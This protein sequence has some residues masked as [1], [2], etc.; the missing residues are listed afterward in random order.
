MSSLRTAVLPTIQRSIDF[1]RMSSPVSGLAQ[2]I[3]MD[4][5]GDLKIDL[6]GIPSPQPSSS[7]FKVW[8]NVWNSSDP[9]SS[10]FNMYVACSRRMC[11]PVSIQ[12]LFAVRT[13][14]LMAHSAH[15]PILIATPPWT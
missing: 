15:L 5:N 13:Q 12:S 8:Q 1:N 4:M 2:P 11:S 6:F 14:S 3:P 9:R 10:L 7:P